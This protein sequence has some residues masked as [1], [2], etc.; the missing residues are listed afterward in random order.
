LQKNIN[1]IKE[2][3]VG[4]WINNLRCLLKQPPEIL[5]CF[6]VVVPA[7]FYFRHKASANTGTFRII[8]NG[9][10]QIIGKMDAPDHC[11]FAIR[12]PRYRGTDGRINTAGATTG[13]TFHV[14]DFFIV[15]F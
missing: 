10:L 14:S 6:F 3:Y 15:N 7:D 12:H 4:K 5:L 9:T 8:E 2:K 11:R 13:P 1:S